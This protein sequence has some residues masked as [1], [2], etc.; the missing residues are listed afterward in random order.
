M[1]TKAIR[2]KI[3]K[4]TGADSIEDVA[5]EVYNLRKDFDTIMELIDLCV[6]DCDNVH[7]VEELKEFAK[8]NKAEFD[9]SDF[10]I[11]GANLLTIN[12]Y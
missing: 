10:Y 9:M 5:F 2:T 11:V 7:N 1:V 12:S 6:M 8:V 3:L 4:V